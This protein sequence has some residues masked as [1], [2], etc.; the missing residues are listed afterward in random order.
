LDEITNFQIAIYGVNVFDTPIFRGAL[1]RCVKSL[2]ENA[3]SRDDFWHGLTKFA[4]KMAFWAEIRESRFNFSER[5][6]IMKEM[7]YA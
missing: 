5:S 6:V 7:E 4:A 1:F 3:E 2:G